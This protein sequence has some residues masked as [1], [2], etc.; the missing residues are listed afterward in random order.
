VVVQVKDNSGSVNGFI[1][2]DLQEAMQ[3]VRKL[4]WYFSIAI[5]GET[6][7]E[8][9]LCFPNIKRTVA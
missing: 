2:S 3:Y 4:G 1:T 8:I 6:A 5:S 9:A 7:T